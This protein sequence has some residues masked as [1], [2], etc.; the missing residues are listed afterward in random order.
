MKI[1]IFDI[2]RFAVTTV[3]EA[4]VCK[5]WANSTW[6]AAMNDIFFGKFTGT[7]AGSII[8]IQTDLSKGNEGDTITIPLL[9]KLTGAG[10]SGDDT[11]EGNEEA[12]TYRNMAVTINQIRN[13]VRLKGKFE[14]KKSKL[15]MRTDA[16]TALQTWLTEKIDSMLFTALTANPTSDR[17]VYASSAKTEVGTTAADKFTTDI[18]GK[19]KRIA[20]TDS[21]ARI[22]P[23]KV[24]KGNYYVMV[25]DPWQARDLKSDEKWLA[26]Q[27]HAA[28]RGLDNP[29][30]TGALGLYDGVVIHEND[31]ISRTATGASGIKVGHALFLGAQAAA[32]AEGAPVEWNEDDFDY[33][34]QKGFA[35][36]RIFGV[37]K[38][39]YKFDGTKDTDFGCIQVVT[40]SVDD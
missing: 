31:Q 2:Q 23:V 40:S 26:A 34:N 12:L 22:R 32:F 16:R 27:Q 10:V 9:M 1:N 15:K 33:H 6:T 18:I 21:N 25:I 17:I 30:F 19:A 36:G 5:A 29:I 4:L 3:P 28:L 37:A 13:G 11:L 35:I 24:N 38:S 14:E 39:K 20:T 8:Q 7:D